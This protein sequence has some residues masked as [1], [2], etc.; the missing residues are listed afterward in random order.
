MAG[1]IFLSLTIALYVLGCH[2][3]AFGIYGR[4]SWLAPMCGLLAY[5]SPFQYGFAN[6]SFGLALFLVVFGLW[7]RSRERPSI[8]KRM[9]L[10]VLTVV[11]YVAHLAGFLFLAIGVV[12][13][14]AF[15]VLSEKLSVRQVLSDVSLLAVP[16]ALQA[17]PWA[18]KVRVGSVIWATMGEKLV[19]VAGLFLSYVYWLD[20]MLLLMILFTFGLLTWRGWL[21]VSRTYFW[22]GALFFLLFLIC[23]KQATIG[24][25]SGAD[26]RFVLPA[27][28]LILLSARIVAPRRWTKTLGIL[29][30][31]CL[32]ARCGEITWEWSRLGLKT[33]RLTAA[34]DQVRPD[35]RIYVLYRIPEDLRE[36]KLARA[37]LH[38]ASYEII[39]RQAIP[40]NFYAVRGA[41][42]IFF[43]DPAQW[44]DSESPRILQRGYLDRQ[45]PKFDYVWGCYLDSSHVGYLSQRA[46]V[47]STAD[48]CS[49]W[50][51]DPSPVKQ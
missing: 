14:T 2:L 28:L 3:L 32:I 11:L 41:E 35:S 24:G 42:P 40:G 4:P 26:D 46:H 34:L 9:A 37:N 17:Y 43:R 6:F 33:A 21:R 18:N 49:L 45:L 51:L 27:T 15:K 5:H 50:Q 10:A 44:A 22:L 12:W 19:G 47:V 25:G 23:P 38:V 16:V 8:P 13:V 31:T 30:L 48:E 1:K 36:A 29:V 20:G 39:R 7:I